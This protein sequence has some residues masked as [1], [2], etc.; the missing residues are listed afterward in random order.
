VRYNSGVECPSKPPN[1]TG[2]MLF[3]ALLCGGSSWTIHALGL[4]WLWAVPLGIVGGMALYIAWLVAV[5]SRRPRG[6]V[7]L[8][9]Y[10]KP[11]RPSV[12][13]K[14]PPTP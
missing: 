8:P 10:E 4:R 14:P 5:D 11:D 1:V 9:P 3:F 7:D 12:P 13:M 2:R 6:C